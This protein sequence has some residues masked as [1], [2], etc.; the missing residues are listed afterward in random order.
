MTSLRS[1]QLYGVNVI[2]KTNFY[3]LLFICIQLRIMY[4]IKLTKDINQNNTSCLFT[5]FF[6]L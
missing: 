4:I 1:A 5:I 6:W 3:L 2:Y